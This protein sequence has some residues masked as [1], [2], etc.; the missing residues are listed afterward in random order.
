MRRHLWRRKYRSTN[1]AQM[2][3]NWV[4]A[5]INFIHASTSRHIISSTRFIGI[6]QHLIKIIQWQSD[7]SPWTVKYHTSVTHL[8]TAETEVYYHV[9]HLCYGQQFL[10]NVDKSCLCVSRMF[11]TTICKT[12]A[13]SFW[14]QQYKNSNHK[15]NI[16][17]GSF[18]TA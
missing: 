2:S 11:I 17:P 15:Y 14:Q 8:C 5:S 16:F 7:H 3:I 9:S 13:S 18:P 10:F 1:K 12:A 4:T 6:S